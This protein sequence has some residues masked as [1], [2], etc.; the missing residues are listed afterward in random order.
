[1]D[2][3]DRPEVP[4]GII[5]QRFIQSMSATAFYATGPAMPAT[6]PQTPATE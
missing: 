1:M 2:P 4:Y 3:E 5:A 6:L